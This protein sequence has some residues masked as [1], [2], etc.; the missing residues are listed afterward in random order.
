MSTRWEIDDEEAPGDRVK[1]AELWGSFERGAS[2]LIEHYLSRE[3]CYAVLQ[4]RPSPD[5]PLSRRQSDLMRR[6]VL[7]E[8]HKAIAT[9]LEI[10]SASVT[11]RLRH[12]AQQFGVHSHWARWPLFLLVAGTAFYAFPRLEVGARLS[13]RLRDGQEH[14]VCS[15]ERPDRDLPLEL[16]TAEQEIARLV[17]QGVA[18][19]EMAAIRG[20]STRT[21][22]NQVSAVFSKLGVSGRLQLVHLLV[23]R[24]AG[25][26]DNFTAGNNSELHSDRQ[27]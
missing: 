14:V 1:L 13:R 21:V 2:R 19:S 27:N 24:A 12:C 3:R 6:L 10:S 11:Q 23:R 9:D 15:F 22:G 20:T 8:Q 18:Q 5:G 7:G 25:R 26:V 17:I 4:P 16:S